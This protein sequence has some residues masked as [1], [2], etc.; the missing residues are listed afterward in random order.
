M[1]RSNLRG[2]TSLDRMEIFVGAWR[3]GLGAD[4]GGSGLVLGVDGAS[5]VGAFNFSLVPVLGFV[6]ACSFVALVLVGS[7]VVRWRNISVAVRS[8]S[9]SD[10]WSGS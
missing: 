8:V 2:V 9:S 10:V 7:V 6:V 3:G 5:V 4:P 1:L